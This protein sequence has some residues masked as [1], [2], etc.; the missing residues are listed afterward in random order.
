LEIKAKKMGRTQQRQKEEEQMLK[1][2]FVQNQKN[3][4]QLETEIAEKMYG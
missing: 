1:N 4:E 2:I 3:T